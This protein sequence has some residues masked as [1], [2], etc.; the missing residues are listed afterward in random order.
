MAIADLLVGATAMPINGAVDLLILHELS[1]EHVCT[2]DAVNLGLK[3]C[4]FF[5]SLYHFTAVAWERYEAIR[6]WMDYK[7]VVTNSRLKTMAIIA[8]LAALITVI[9]P[10][11]VKRIDVDFKFIEIWLIIVFAGGI[12]AFLAIVYFYVLVYLGVR[13]R[14]VDR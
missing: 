10:A 7:T 6:K 13:Q 4:F 12:L 11:V 5:S 8:W 1:V 9:P 3:F 14:R 2:L